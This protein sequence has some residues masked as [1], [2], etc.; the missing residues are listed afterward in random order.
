MYSQARYTR[1]IKKIR[2]EVELISILSRNSDKRL[3]V[4]L[5]LHSR[6]DVKMKLITEDIIIKVLKKELVPCVV[7]L[8]SN[9]FFKFMYSIKGL[10]SFG[11]GHFLSVIGYLFYIRCG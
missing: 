3:F 2:I 9:E 11:M 6:I 5:L 10:W 8:N 4:L 1:S 7:Q